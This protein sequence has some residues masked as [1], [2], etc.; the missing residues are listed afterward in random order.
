MN[1]LKKYLTFHICS[2]L[3]YY[4][5]FKIPI[6]GVAKFFFLLIPYFGGINDEAFHFLNDTLI[7]SIF[8]T[9]IFF[10]F[11]ILIFSIELLIH[12]LAKL[13]FKK[14]LSLNFNNRYYNIF[15]SIGLLCFLYPFSPFLF[16]FAPATILCIINS[17]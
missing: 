2:L 9:F 5:I 8:F 17:L 6:L 3:G 12:L 15:F 1:F 16:Y 14:D 4:F 7:V 11:F 13:I 10:I